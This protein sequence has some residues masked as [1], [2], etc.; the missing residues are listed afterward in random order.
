M[1]NAYEEYV[2]SVGYFDA[3]IFLESDANEEICTPAKS[4]DEDGELAQKIQKRTSMQQHFDKVNIFF[5]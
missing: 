2:L 3:R 5:T 1:K 4:R